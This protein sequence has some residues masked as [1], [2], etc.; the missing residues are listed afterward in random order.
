MPNWYA[1][2]SAVKRATATDTGTTRDPQIDR[3]IEAASREIDRWT[4]RFFI[5]RTETRLYRWPPT[6]Y[7]RSWQLWLDQDLIAVTTLKSEAQDTSPTT[8]ASSDFFVEPNN[9]GP[10]YDRIEIDQSSSAVFQAGDTQQRSISVLGRWGYSEDTLGAGTVSSGLSSDATA[11][12]MIGSDGSLIDVG[13][14]LLIETEQVFV[15]E[16][17]NAAVGSELIDG[18]LTKDKGEV[19]VT[20][21]DGTEVSAGEVIL[22]E[23]ERMLI[24]SI[25]GNVLT[26]VRGFDG[27]AVAAHNNDTAFHAFRT[28]TIVRAVNGTTAATHA[29]GT[30]V[31][32]YAPE[33]DIVALCVAEATRIIHQERSG[34]GRTI[35]PA[36]G[37]TVPSGQGLDELRSAVYGHLTRVRQAAI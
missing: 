6:Q 32:R 30:A 28:Y 8:I 20:I 10:P 31:S 13:D 26:V 17:A 35:G 5:P 36:G 23:S 16:V 25:S 9:Q 33:A 12:E 21:D 24:E 29:N 2:R 14:T 22:I 34:W 1:G 19:A 7:G 3:A 4:R 18:A 37:A 15:T 27:S 11:T